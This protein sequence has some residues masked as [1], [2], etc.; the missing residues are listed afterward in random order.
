MKWFFNFVAAGDGDPPENARK[1]IR[2]I[3]RKTVSQDFL[4]HLHYALLGLG[5]TNYSTFCGGPKRLEKELKAHGATS[6]YPTA[7]ADDAVG[8][9]EVVEPWI[10]GLFPA[11]QSHINVLS[12]FSPNLKETE[13]DC[14]EMLNGCEKSLPVGVDIVENFTKLNIDCESK[15]INLLESETVKVSQGTESCEVSLNLIGNV[16]ESSPIVKS[17]KPSFMDLTLPPIVPCYLDLKLDDSKVVNA[18]FMS[19]QNDA[20]FAVASSDIFKA[21]ILSAKQISQDNAIKR[22]IEIKLG[23]KEVIDFYPGDSFAICCRN[24]ESEVNWL[25][26]R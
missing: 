25:I 19:Y 9:E 20:A 3:S 13:L 16:R 4:A 21:T 7:F 23:V 1:F 10:D 14:N 15:S 22:A 8:L 26:N 24:D 5:D 6:F 17:T 12:N 11:L 2:S 18:S